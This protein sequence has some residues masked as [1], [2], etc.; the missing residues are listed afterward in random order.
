MIKRCVADIETDG[1]LDELTLLYCAS[2]RDFETG[3]NQRFRS[4]KALVHHLATF[5]EVWFHNGCSFD[6]PALCLLYP[7]TET[8]LPR[9]RVRDTL[10]LSRL[11]F[12]TLT[13]LDA[14]KSRKH[15]RSPDPYPLPGYLKGSHSL[16]AWGYRLGDYKGDFN[17]TDYMKSDGSYNPPKDAKQRKAE[18]AIRH[19]WKTVGYSEDMA[20]YCDQDTLVTQK[21]LG[22][23]LS[24][25][26]PE[27][28]FNLEHDIAWL[29]AKQERNGFHFD[30]PAAAALY[31]ELCAKRTE[32]TRKLK[33]VFGTWYVSNGTS[34][35]KRTV[36][37]KDKLRGS[38]VKDAPY[39]K[40]KIIEFN[41]G[42][43]THVARCFK[44]W[45]G[46]E[47]TEFTDGGEPKVDA[48]VLEKLNYPEAALLK[49][50]YDINKLIGQLGDGK[51]AWLKLERNGWIHGRVNPNGAG[52]GRATHSTPNVAQV[53]KG[54]EGT[55]GHRC[56]QLFGVPRGWL[57]L[58]SDASGLELRCLGNAL[59]PY[60]GGKYA[61]L[62]VNGDIHWH[63]T[64]A[65]GLVPP[66][67]VRDKHNPEHEDAR[68]TSKRW[69][70]AFLY[71][72]GNE[73][74]GEIAGYDASERDAWREKKAHKKVIAFLTKKGERWNPHR[75]CNI[76][77]G[78]QLR[79]AFLKA[80]PA[81]KEFQNECKEE[82]KGDVKK[83]ADGNVMRDSS[84]DEIRINKGVTG[85]DGRFIPTR[86]AHSATNFRL[87]G[88][89]AL[90]C[91]LWGVLIERRLQAEGLT[92]G[93]DGDYA[94]CA[95][96]HDEYQIA[97]RNESI[98]HLVGRVCSE[99][100]K[101]VGQIFKINCELDAEYDLGD[102]WSQTH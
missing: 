74:L 88:D 28:A 96:V 73:L 65:L 69:I 57:L 99:T 80:I 86:S 8:V 67:T 101:E 79:K 62:V 58:G 17:P 32:S 66:G 48:E 43:R 100:M 93:W 84:G 98:G 21:L 47:P 55:Y 71:G 30:V 92:H 39:T 22:L 18:A 19:T 77:K 102:N 10:V 90:I 42:S 3:R 20:D 52:T 41:P 12:P 29:M 68:D 36:N 53:P 76:L 51:N 87:Q 4:V 27:M 31:A 54:N 63:N 61:D 9:E 35:P 34:C 95:W 85:L 97:V 49:D 44:L 11:L 72:A 13:Q 70:Y 40:V 5:D 6:Y 50:F 75:V 60:D 14:F 56:R 2:A 91:K 15:K 81:V 7:A 82:H 59:A 25:D 94:F 64:I 83:D 1:L 45:Y 16:G 89:G 23:L 46:W 38:T 37:Y 26:C 24:K 33:E 78:E